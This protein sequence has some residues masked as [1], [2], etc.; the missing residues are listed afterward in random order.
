[1]ENRFLTFAPVD[2]RR[3]PE[4]VPR[5][6]V[7]SQVSRPDPKPV[8]RAAPPAVIRGGARDQWLCV[9]IIIIIMC[10]L[11]ETNITIVVIIIVVV[12]IVSA[13]SHSYYYSVCAR[14]ERQGPRERGVADASVRFCMHV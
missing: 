9:I 6:Q 11:G 8:S 4:P 5:T 1:M 14:L 7:L 3:K 10:T 13:I 2:F 12:I